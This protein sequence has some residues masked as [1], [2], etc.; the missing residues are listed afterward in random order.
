MD[1]EIL[2][3]VLDVHKFVVLKRKMK[4]FLIANC[5]EGSGGNRLVNKI[6]EKIFAFSAFFSPSSAL[7]AFFRIF[8]FF[9]L[10]GLFSPFP[11]LFNF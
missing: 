10:F 6:A 5:V 8:G 3:L 11:P 2:L 1:G 9:R 7:S 4:L